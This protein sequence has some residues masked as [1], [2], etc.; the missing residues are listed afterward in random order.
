MQ[1]R[2]SIPLFVV[3]FF[4]AVFLGIES[5]NAVPASAI[6]DIARSVARNGDDILAPL[7]IFVA[8]LSQNPFLL[9]TVLVILGVLGYSVA[10][11]TK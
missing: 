10:K 4:C 7:L 5:V 11:T 8:Y 3:G 1:C 9:V 6:D 2:F